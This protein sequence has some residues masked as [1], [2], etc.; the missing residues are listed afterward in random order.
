MSDRST[1]ENPLSADG[2]RSLP[3]CA[4]PAWACGRALATDRHPM[5]TAV[6]LPG[7]APVKH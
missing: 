1:V 7:P 2:P 6:E 4:Y 3:Y 5:T